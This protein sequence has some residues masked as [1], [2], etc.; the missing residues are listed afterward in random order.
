MR[1]LFRAVLLS[2]FCTASYAGTIDDRLAD[3]L[4]SMQGDERAECMLVMQEQFDVVAF[5]HTMTMANSTSQERH[6]YVINSLQEIATRTQAG[7]LAYLGNASQN[8]LIGEYRS[9]WISNSIYAQLSKNAVMAIAARDDVEGI[10]YWEEPELIRPVSDYPADDQPVIAGVERGLEA[11][12]APEVWARGYTG[13]GRL[14]ANVDTGVDGNHPALN[15]RWRGNNGAPPE[16]SWL[17]TANPSSEF[18]YDSDSHGTHTMGTTTG[19]GESTGDTIGVAFGA[20]WIAARAIVSGGNV[21]MAFQW[22]ADPDGDPNTIDDVPDVISNS[23]GYHDFSCPQYQWNLI[24]NC[25]AAG[26]VV[27]FAAGNRFSGDPYAESMWA[28]A[29]R[30][31][32]PYN[33]FSVGA[34]NGASDNFPIAD[35]SARG[36]SQ[37]DHSTIKPEVVA[38]GVNVRSSVPG[39][40][41]QQNGWSGTSMACPHVA[42]AIALL[43]Q[44]N[45]NATVDT[46]KWAL[47]ETA[48][49]L[50]QGGDDNTYG[51]GIINVSEALSIMPS[52]ELPNLY[53]YGSVIQ[54]PNDDYPD[55]GEDIE[56]VLTL[57]NTGIAA[58]NVFATLS[59][60]DEYAAITQDSAFY[61]NIGG[62]ETADNS[63][64]PFEITFS[65]T[66][67]MGRLIVFELSIQGDGY[68]TSASFTIRVGRLDEPE[69]ADFD[70]GDVDFT[71]SNFGI[72]GLNPPEF[73]PD[74]GGQG[75]KTP[76][77]SANLLFE[78]ALMIG[79]GPTRVSNGARDE[80][81]IIAS[82]FVPLTAI[83]QAEPGEFGDQEYSCAFNDQDAMEPL[84]I[85]VDQT[86]YAWAEAPDDIYIITEYDITNNG[87]T[88]LDGV[89]VAHYE[90][91]DMPWGVATDRANFDR[92][93]NLG[94]QFYQNFYRGMMVLNAEGAS[95]FRALHNSTE[96][97]PPA[98]TLADK[99]EYMT[100]GFSDT[101]IT[102]MEDASMMLTT[103]PFD[104]PFGA[105]VTAAFAILGANSLSALQTVADA[106]IAKYD[107]L[108]SIEDN[109]GEAL[110]EAFGISSTYPNP[111]N[112]STS[113]RFS[114]DKAGPIE[115]SIYNIMGQKVRTLIDEQRLPGTYEVTWN[116][117]N[118]QGGEV[119]SG[120]YFVRLH[121]DDRTSSKKML[122][123]R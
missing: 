114:L 100:S 31:T 102:T 55:P 27:V 107:Q 69:S 84:E 121:S 59:T 56:L 86:S 93:R 35:F 74:W 16:E 15:S 80:E 6:A 78:G 12:H 11:I 106:V 83:D 82:D 23:W 24:D 85:T 108:T 20:Q 123:L 98:F 48:M 101:A 79:D 97:Y 72:Y 5:K 87:D 76:R 4:T 49:D 47:A 60:D 105:T 109:F 3:K 7:I 81:Q 42:G 9:Y 10:Y 57:A 104:I 75:F 120:M 26:I 89:L 36:P 62:G 17:D 117:R 58:T 68:S 88:N 39:G 61:G 54:E 40:G 116:G 122:L 28:P 37:C 115:I 46:I 38:P 19:L 111:F 63:D 92:S 71:I 25:E 50:G 29:S 45:P 43:R 77:G 8:K 34:V 94:Y 51:R 90:D 53:V 2:A 70:I 67:P 64:Q 91:W 113:I 33:T 99:W 14:V 95:S 66:T 103:G 96:V 1:N 22:L 52:N 30:N 65:E 112:P 32:T 13:A 21:S 110:P 41:Y 118:G 44:Y 18:P 119:A 73:Y